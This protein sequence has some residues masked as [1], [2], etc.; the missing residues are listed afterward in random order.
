MTNVAK[1]DPDLAIKIKQQMFTFDDLPRLS[2]LQMQALFR[3]IPQLKWALALRLASD[4]VKEWVFKNISKRTL[5]LLEEEITALGPQRK[6]DIE[7]AQ[8]EI[9][10][11]YQKL[12]TAT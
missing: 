4:P 10:E 2:E 7:T 3:S 1:Q 11:A 8:Q 5:E 12:R 9:I 6:T